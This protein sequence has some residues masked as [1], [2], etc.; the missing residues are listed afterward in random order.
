MFA[1]SFKVEERKFAS[2]GSLQKGESHARRL[3]KLMK[4]AKTP[5][6]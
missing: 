5:F 2:S 4:K 6:R 3:I 1:S